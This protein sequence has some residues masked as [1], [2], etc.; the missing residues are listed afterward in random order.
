MIE[1]R[2]PTEANITQMRE[3]SEIIDKAFSFLKS[4]ASSDSMEVVARKLTEAM[5]WHNHC[6]LNTPAKEESSAPFVEAVVEEV[7]DPA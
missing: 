6:V 1:F 3:F 4:C 5:L 7:I 2:S